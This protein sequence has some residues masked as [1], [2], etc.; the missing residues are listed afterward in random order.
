MKIND[1]VLYKHIN[2]KQYDPFM[3]G[4]VYI[5]IPLKEPVVS[6]SKFVETSRKLK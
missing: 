4:K 6:R 5:S 1:K 3:Y 2:G